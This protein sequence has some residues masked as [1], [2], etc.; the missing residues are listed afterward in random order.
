Y[1]G[2]TY[3]NSSA[4]ENVRIVQNISSGVEP[5]FRIGDVDW[6]GVV[7]P[8]ESTK[9]EELNLAQKKFIIE[10]TG[11]SIFSG[12]IYYSAD[13]NLFKEDL[14]ED[15]ELVDWGE[16]LPAPGT[17]TL[18]KDITP[19]QK[20]HALEFLKYR[21]WTGPVYYNESAA[22]SR[23]YM[24]ALEEG[25]DYKNSTVQ[26]TILDLPDAETAFDNLSLE[27][28]QDL[29]DNEDLTQ[30]QL[31][32][33]TFSGLSDAQKKDLLSLKYL[34]TDQQNAILKATGYTEIE[35]NFYFKA[36]ATDPAKRLVTS[37]LEGVEYNNSDINFSG[38]VPDTT[39]RWVVSDGTNKYMVYALDNE[40]DGVVDEIQIQDPHL[41]VGQRGYGFLLTGTV[42]SLEANKSLVIASEDETI[43]RGNINL[44]GSSSDLTAQSDDWVYWE[45][46]ADVTGNL[47]VHGGVALDGTDLNGANSDGTSVF[48]HDTATLNTKG[49]GTSITIKGSKDV[50]VDGRVVS[51]GTIG[52]SGVTFAGDD[53]SAYVTAGEYIYVDSVITAAKEVILTTTG[54]PGADDSGLGVQLTTASG[55]TTSGQTSANTGG[56]VKID[57]VGSV[58]AMGIILSGGTISQTFD[59]QGNLKTETIT[60]SNED[61]KVHL[62][63][64][65][66]LYLGGMTKTASGEDVEVGG[67]V[68][69]TEKVTLIGGA[70]SDDIGVKLPGAA[71]VQTYNPD[72]VIEITAAEDAEIYG[73]LAA[74]GEIVD[75]RDANGLF[76]GNTIK[77]FDGSS[78]I[79]ISA[80]HQV[81]LGRELLA[82]KVID[83]RGGTDPADGSSLFAGN[84]IVLGG[85]AKLRTWETGSTINLSASGDARVL[86]PAWT[87]EVVAAGFSEFADGHISQNVTIHMVVD[88]GTHTIEGNVLLKASD[89][90]GNDG[91]GDLKE[92]LQNAVNATDFNVI[93]SPSGDPA[94]NS[95]HTIDS[96][97]PEVEVG[98]TDGRFMFRGAYEITLKSDSTNPNL[99]G[100]SQ[101]G[102]GDA[103][104]GRTFTIDAPKSGSVINIGKA[105]S[106]GGE[107]YIAGK[108]RAFKG[109]NLHT[110]VNPDGSQKFTLG[111]TG[112][113]E[114]LS[115]G[116]VLNPGDNG[117]ITGEIIARGQGADI[118]INSKDTLEIKGKL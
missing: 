111:A 47:T 25:V 83:V 62:E 78:E 45:G 19:E 48:I 10:N 55:L 113:L 89:T 8:E 53:S 68:R 102:T 67:I 35:Q 93:T 37:F 38:D 118:T 6:G 105:G 11:Y 66:Q 29:F 17:G 24:A 80:D 65:T 115:G 5:D 49:A 61:S 21:E 84:G 116:I 15:L 91:L 27:L 52:S 117:V 73:L 95:T 64:D 88:L 76:L 99:L 60:Y 16:D 40:N 82:G 85:T 28:A 101:L 72:G 100:F 79:H 110:G 36:N 57:A 75:H 42:T 54:T 97:E 51:G 13:K 18:F 98:L 30:V 1:K 86:A 74:G 3:Y 104:S 63:S 50:I 70:S 87:E 106:P 41:L 9:F 69:T 12:S 4:A 31:D 33:K 39:T 23:R 56:L 44:F 58:S 34:S 92:D 14:T 71:M 2:G 103:K 22:E 32:A 81:R 46:R 59:A 94:V 77:T 107:I 26:W 109:I 108:L 20:T 112:V 90:T 43:L 114:T 96:S 7:E